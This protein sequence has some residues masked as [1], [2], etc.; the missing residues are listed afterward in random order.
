[1]TYLTCM[2]LRFVWFSRLTKKL[3]WRHTFVF[4][5]LVW[6]NTLSV[7]LCKWDCQVYKK[8][9][10][11]NRNE[12]KLGVLR[13]QTHATGLSELLTLLK[14]TFKPQAFS[15]RYYLL[16]ME[17]KMFDVRLIPEFN[18]AAANMPIVKIV[19]LVCKLCTM[20]NVECVLP[21]RLQGGDLA[22]YRQ[23]SVEWKADAE[24]IK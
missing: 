19:E 24:L 15:V 20:K 17:G 9:R 6:N 16:A 12:L 23:L 5:Y 8:S 7:L 3:K 4:A 10:G 21:L 14:S 13:R 2:W 18:G 11:G 1:M 22:I